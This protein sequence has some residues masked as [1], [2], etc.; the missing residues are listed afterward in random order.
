ML[1]KL[2]E[3]FKIT[4]GLDNFRNNFITFIEGFTSLEDIVQTNLTDLEEIVGSYDAAK[5]LVYTASER[6]LNKKILKAIEFDLWNHIST[7]CKSIDEIIFGGIPTVGISEVY[8]CS[9]VGKTQ[10]CLQLALNI[11]LPSE[12]KNT[13]KGNISC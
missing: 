13:G 7:G 10:F 6:L 5:N 2:K 11:Q 12:S 9:G 1:L 8:G 4:I 3:H